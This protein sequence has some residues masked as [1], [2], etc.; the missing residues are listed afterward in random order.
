MLR[1][2]FLKW[3]GLAPVAAAMPALGIDIATPAVAKTAVAQTV[4]KAASYH[5]VSYALGYIITKEEIDDN[6]FRTMNGRDF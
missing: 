4:T 5:H 6:L 2:T 3:M 1:R